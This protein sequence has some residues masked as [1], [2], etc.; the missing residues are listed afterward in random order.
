MR[1]N[2]TPN[3]T[4]EELVYAGD[5]F[6]RET[7]D[8][9]KFTEMQTFAWDATDKGALLH[10]EASPSKSELAYK[11]YQATR[12]KQFEENRKNILERYGGEDNL[13]KDALFILE[14]D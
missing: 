6:L 10:L 4:K 1:E 5:N 14:Q 11:K 7:G 12:T 3:K 9:L 2:P 13:E 8:S